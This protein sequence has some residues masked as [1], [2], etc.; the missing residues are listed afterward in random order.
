M[1]Y[2]EFIN[3]I[4]ETRGR[5]GCGDKYYERHHITPRCCG[6]TD[7]KDNLI[8]LFA[9]EHFIAHKLLALENPDNDK[10]IYAWWCMAHFISDN[11]NREEIS[12]DEYALA[13]KA[14]SETHSKMISGENHPLY[15]K[16]RTEEE[17]IKMS[18]NRKG[19]CV[20][21]DNPNYGKHFSEETRRKQSESKIGDKNPRFGCIVS[22][23]TKK[24]L[25]EKAMNK[26]T[27]PIYC[28]QLDKYFIGAM[29]VF[30]K[31][32]IDQSDITKCCNGKKKTAGVHS[33]TGERLTWRYA[34]EEEKNTLNFT[35]NLEI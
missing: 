20:G 31:Y 14:F 3:N 12:P 29:F 18:I 32:H 22:D 2:K 15:G 28:P 7:D 17:K 35:N 30:K 1:T 25:S 11:Q 26:H 6:G 23:E 33:Q 13:R 27:K 10:L 4:I 9:D 19:K 5:F 21:C 8:D 34:T 16:H 24:I